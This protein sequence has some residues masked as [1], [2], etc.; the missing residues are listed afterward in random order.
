MTEI[1]PHSENIM[2]LFYWTPSSRRFFFYLLA[3]SAWS[4][5]YIYSMRSTTLL[6]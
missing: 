1:M 3:Y 2:N 4:T 5:V 6:L